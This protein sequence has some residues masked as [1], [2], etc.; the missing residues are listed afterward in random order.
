[1]NEDTFFSDQSN[2]YNDIFF[3]NAQNNIIEEQKSV[4][5]ILKYISQLQNQGYSCKYIY[6]RLLENFHSSEI[7]KYIEDIRELFGMEGLIGTVV[8]DARNFDSCKEAYDCA[9]QSPYKSYIQGI[10]G[11]TCGKCN[12]IKVDSTYETV[13]NDFFAS[14]KVT[15]KYISLCNETNYRQLNSVDEIENNKF[16]N[17][18]KQLKIAGTDDLSGIETDDL[19]GN[20]KKAFYNLMNKNSNL[21]EIII[22]ND[23]NE[24]VEASFNFD[25]EQPISEKE[26]VDVGFKA[27]NVE[28]NEQQTNEKDLNVQMGRI[29]NN[30]DLCNE[31]EKGLDVQIDS[32]GEVEL[33]KAIITKG[34]YN[35]D[36]N[37]MATT[38]DNVG[39]LYSNV[40]M[41]SKN[42][43][44][45]INI[46]LANELEKIDVQMQGK[47]KISFVAESETKKP[48]DVSMKKN[49]KIELQKESNKQA[50]FFVDMYGEGESFDTET[51]DNTIFNVETGTQ[52]LVF[53]DSNNDTFF[54]DIQIDDSD[55]NID[56]LGEEQDFSALDVNN[57]ITDGDYF[58]MTNLEGPIEFSDDEDGGL[59]F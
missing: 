59:V 19:M 29:G 48:V 17:I 44:K 16:S 46:A 7:N 56:L 1:M 41:T 20:V 2:N 45:S 50:D 5:V 51:N 58:D 27:S 30:I 15:D 28:I 38:Y 26:N 10:I 11:C 54:S 3:D 21:K 49:T 23:D 55:L 52:D 53:N 4:P 36:L 14:E 31:A 37:K 24:Q 40:E 8:I 12:K 42:K 34:K 57:E 18:L 33:N 47:E 25:I 6:D 13:G 32:H 9:K 35:I 22:V 39:S 43:G